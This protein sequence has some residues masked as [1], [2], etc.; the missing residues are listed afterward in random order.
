M[1]FSRSDPKSA[2]Y[3]KYYSQEDIV[4]LFSPEQQTIDSVTSW[5]VSSGIPKDSIHL[6]KSQGWIA[7]DTTAS[8]LESLLKT[9]Y[10]T[11]EHNERGGKYVG[12]DEYQLPNEVSDYID[13]VSPGVAFSAQGKGTMGSKSQPIV[14]MPQKLASASSENCSEAITPECIRQMYNISR[15]DE[16]SDGNDLGVFELDIERYSQEDLDEFYTKYASEIPKGTGPSLA[17]V[18]GGKA[19]TDQS[20]AGSEADLDFEIGIPLVYP[21]GSV[22][23]Q[24]VGQEDDDLFDSFLD[25]VDGTYCSKSNQGDCGT[26]KPVPVISFSWG[27]SEVDWPTNYLKVRTL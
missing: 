26:F 16:A 10:Y 24:V 21:Q 20:K 22:N 11:Y 7:F 17:S 27:A 9:K 2:D 18:N 4:S 19:P 13:F 12:T 1:L 23:Y 6:R 3:G 25:A 5:L 15:L 14:P 8:K